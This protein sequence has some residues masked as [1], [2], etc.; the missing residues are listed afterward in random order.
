[1]PRRSLRARDLRLDARAPA[2]WRPDAKT[3][4]QGLDP[5]GKPANPRA[6]FRIGAADAVVDD[7]HHE[8]TPRHGN[9]H[10][11]VVRLRMLPDVREALGDDVVRRDLDPLGEP[12]LKVDREPDRK[13]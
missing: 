7:L 8:P 1:C 3:A 6:A 4:A 12:P 13:G 10:A 2:A 11:R 5:V 9:P